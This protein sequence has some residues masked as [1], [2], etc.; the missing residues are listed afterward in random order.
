MAIT[1]VGGR[2]FLSLFIL[3]FALMFVGGGVV[4]GALLYLQMRDSWT[5]RSYVPVSAQVESVVLDQQSS[6]KGGT[7]YLTRAEFSYTFQGSP[8]V[9]RRVNFSR[10]SDDSK[11][12]HQS[13]YAHLLAAQANQRPVELW[14]DPSNPESSVHDRSVRWDMSLTYLIVG[15]IFTFIGVKVLAFLYRGWRRP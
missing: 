14:V 13:M 2:I 15:S 8:Y 11:S 7:T 4:S 5:A 1:N 9:S 6:R 12:Y 10:T 3:G